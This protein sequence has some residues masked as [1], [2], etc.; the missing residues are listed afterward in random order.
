MTKHA[1]AAVLFVCTAFTVMTGC[2][3]DVPPAPTAQ[4]T[5]APTASPGSPASVSPSPPSVPPSAVAVPPSASSTPPADS[6]GRRPDLAYVEVAPGRL[7]PLRVGEP[8]PVD[9]GLVEWVPDYCEDPYGGGAHFGAWVPVYPA[10]PTPYFSGDRPPF[11]V[12]VPATG[13]GETGENG[14]IGGIIVVSPELTTAEGISPG[15]TRAELEAAYPRTD[16]FTDGTET[17]VY[18]VNGTEGQLRF[19]VMNAGVAPTAGLGPDG[20][21]RVLWILIGGD[22]EGPPTGIYGTD[23]GSACF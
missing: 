17:D 13:V 19:E 11:D 20:A 2:A 9:S 10:K 1:P 16:G 23:A 5:Q 14:T 15:S 21:D 3:S 4:A 8:V 6:E 7:G 22:T 18:A 12:I